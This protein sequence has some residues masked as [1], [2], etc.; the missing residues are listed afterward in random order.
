L[1]VPNQ[2]NASIIRSSPGNFGAYNSGAQSSSLMV[3]SSPFAGDIFGVAAGG[4]HLTGSLAGTGG[5]VAGSQVIPANPFSN[6]PSQFN[7][8][9]PFASAPANPVNPF[10]GSA[11][12]F[13]GPSNSNLFVPSGQSSGFGVSTS[14]PASFGVSVSPFAGG[15]NPSASGGFGVSPFASGATP[16]GGFGVSPFAGG[17]GNPPGNYGGAPP[18]GGFG[19]GASPFAGGGGNPPG[20]Y[21]GN[22][23]GS[24]GGNPTGSYGGASGGFVT[25][26]PYAGGGGNP[27]SNYG[28][29][30]TPFGAPSGGF[31][32]NMSLT[33][34]GPFMNPPSGQTGASNPFFFNN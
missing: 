7:A 20:S 17:G 31:T 33:P 28:M 11:G 23:P 30:S 9:H 14:G 32:G 2:I 34:S 5:N 1:Q 29:G 21:G 15:G 10:A 16:S 18:S 27:S 4:S 8:N 6:N 25:G 26:A 24:Y 3:P 12:G 22:P 19:T 13:G